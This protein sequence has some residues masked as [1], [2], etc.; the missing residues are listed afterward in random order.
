M[1]NGVRMCSSVQNF[2]KC[3]ENPEEPCSADIYI[4]FV[5]ILTK[6]ASRVLEMY[7]DSPGVMPDCLKF[8]LNM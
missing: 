4:D 5:N 7:K 2:I 6:F 1:E 8:H 3:Y